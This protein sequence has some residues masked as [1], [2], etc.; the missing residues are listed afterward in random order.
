MSQT[1]SGIITM[2][3]STPPAVVDVDVVTLCFEG[4]KNS[5]VK[6]T[7]PLVIRV[8]LYCALVA[9]VGLTV[10]GNLLVIV[11][12]LHFKQLHTPT[13]YLIL[14]LALADLL[15]G[16]VVMPPSVV[17]VVESCWYWGALF[18]KVHNSTSMMC[19]TASI[20]NLTMISIDRYYAICQPLLYRTKISVSVVLVMDSVTWIVA[21]LFGFGVVFL[22]LNLIGIRNL[23]DML[24]CDGSCI[25]LHS[26]VSGALSALVSFYLPGVIMACI[27]LKIFVLARAQL[28]AIH[29]VNTQANGAPSISKTERKATKTLIII[30]GAFI[31][32]W[33]PFFLVFNIDAYFGYASPPVVLEIFGWVGYLNSTVNP[34]VYAYFYRWFRQAFQIIMSGKI[35][36]QHSSR[37]ALISD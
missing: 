6:S 4:V 25:F 2:T 15:V 29:S 23:Y 13:N 28:K 1:S 35:F 19:C 26:L 7:Y 30:M 37:I 21:A 34:L 33:I 12:V 16:V 8:P 18:C 17:R 36:Q 14:S 5:C 24:A 3:N 32:S 27:Y 11:A 9:A 10:L 20:V 31:A 22:E